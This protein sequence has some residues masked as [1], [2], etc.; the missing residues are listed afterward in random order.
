M[1]KGVYPRPTEVEKFWRKTRRRSNGCWEWIG[2]LNSAG[3]GVMKTNRHQV[4]VHRWAYERYVG[5]IPEGLEPDHLCNVRHCVNPEHIE[6]V[7][8]AE[9]NRR[10]DQRK[11]HCYMRG[12][13]WIPEN[14]I[15][16]QGRRFCRPC[17]EIRQRARRVA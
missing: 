3:Y 14:W 5:P 15:Y 12:H 9:N 1:P 13:P 10:R 17:H 8:S 11:T 4:R 16:F 7:T 2:T 6:L